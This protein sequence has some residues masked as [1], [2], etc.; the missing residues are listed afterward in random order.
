MWVGMTL[1]KNGLGRLCIIS[2]F[3]IV[4][5]LIRKWHERNLSFV[6][7]QIYGDVIVLLI[8]LKLLVGPSIRAMSASGTIS[9]FL[10]LMFLFVLLWLNKRKLR[11]ESKMLRALIAT[12]I[13]FGTIAVF[14]GGSNVAF[15]SSS[16]GRD[17]TLTGRTEIWNGLIP[18]AMERFVTGYGV[19]GF[20]TDLASSKHRYNEAHNGY[21]EIILQYGFFGL[22]IFIIFLLS[23]CRK[24]QKV[25]TQDFAWG[26]LCFCYLLMAVVHNIAESSLD[27][28]ASHLTAV[29]M[30][31]SVV[32]TSSP[33]STFKASRPA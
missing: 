17:Q 28:F 22:L 29:V 24:T 26:T 2:V 33:F 6:K 25:M 13:I 16:V 18:D 31:L 5:D 21:L 7:Y 27:S 23:F 15:L 1:Q 4:W 20:W 8:S 14:T 10:G 19:G 3:F 9:L 30:F 11:V 12:I 32:C